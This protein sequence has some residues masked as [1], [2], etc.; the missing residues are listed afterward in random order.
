[1]VENSE[2]VWK[3]QKKGKLKSEKIWKCMEG[4]QVE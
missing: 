3:V 1:M 2:K 4:R